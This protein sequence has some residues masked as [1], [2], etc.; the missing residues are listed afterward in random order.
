MKSQY[1]FSEFLTLQN[2]LSS[3][4]ICATF[5]EFNKMEVSGK[6]PKITEN[7]HRGTDI[8]RRIPGTPKNSKSSER[9]KLALNT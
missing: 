8:T 4:N 5:I 1:N 9:R 6:L 7:K 3:W 2:I